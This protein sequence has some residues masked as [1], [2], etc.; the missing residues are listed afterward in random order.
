[1]SVGSGG[2]VTAITFDFWNTLMWEGPDALRSSRLAA[3]GGLLEERGHDVRADLIATAHQ[4]AFEQY[5]SAWRANRQYC[6]PDAVRCIIEQLQLPRDDDL[7][8]TLASAFDAGGDAAEL[9]LANGVEE[10]LRAV[11][12]SGLKIGIVCDIGLTPSPVLR[13]RLD[14]HRL[15]EL[16][17]GWAFS[18]EVGVYKPSTAIFDHALVR[19][20]NPDPASTAHVGDRRRT[21]VAGARARGMIAVRYS[22]V[23]DDPDLDEPEADVVLD[24]LAQLPEALG[25]GS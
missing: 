6:V 12:A 7:D 2:G 19:M 13:R 20:G 17:D 23:Y 3:L 4:V 5:Q 1:M 24:N 25:I 11:R 9:H 14:R 22:G 10:C 8:A 15:L 16:F 21:D 18:D